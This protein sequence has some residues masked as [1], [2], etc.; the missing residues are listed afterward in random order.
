M[1]VPVMVVD[2]RRAKMQLQVGPL[3]RRP[4]LQKAARLGDIARQ[5]AAA[6]AHEGDEL[7]H[8]PRDAAHRETGRL[9]RRHALVDREIDVVD[10]VLADFGRIVQDLDA[11][12]SQMPGRPDAG[13]HQQLR[14]IER[15]RREHD[16][17][18]RGERLATAAAHHVH[19]A[20]ALAVEH[21]AQHRGIGDRMEIGA[22]AIVD[23]SA[24]NAATPAIAL[25]DLIEADAFLIGA[26]E[27]VVRLVARFHR[28]LHETLRK[29]VPVAQVGHGERAAVAVPRIGAALVALGAAEVRQ[30]VLPR[31]AVAAQLRPF[32]VIERMAARVDHRVDRARSAEAAPRAAGSLGGRRV[33]VA[34]WSDSRSW[35]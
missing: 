6:V 25:R 4:A 33:P 19:A 20:R 32:V 10:Q 7:R 11:M 1:H 23:I 12:R 35:S 16:F 17:G 34:A 18:A 28:G 31:P 26:V 30:H 14:R 24:R 5:H 27:V 9:D 13:A 29:R 15:A 3:E 2:E 22:L 8:H 21:H